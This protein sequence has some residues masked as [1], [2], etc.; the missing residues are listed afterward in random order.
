MNKLKSAEAAKQAILDRIA[1]KIAASSEKT[2]V[3]ALRHAAHCSSKT[4][5]GNAYRH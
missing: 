2:G 4:K 1:K 5:H 3:S